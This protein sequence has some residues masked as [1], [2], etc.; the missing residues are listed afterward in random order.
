MKTSVS[1]QFVFLML[2]LKSHYLDSNSKN[3]LAILANLL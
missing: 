3:V 2:V 1:P